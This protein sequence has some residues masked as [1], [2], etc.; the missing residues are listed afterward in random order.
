MFR[1]LLL[2]LLFSAMTSPVLAKIVAEQHVEKEIM[3][4]GDNGETRTER[5]KAEKVVPGE[6]VIY[7]L[8]FSNDADETADAVVLVMPVPPEVSYV[9]GT[10]AGQDANVTFSADGGQTYVARGRLTVAED[11]V[12]RPA[13]SNEITHIKWTLAETLPAKAKSEVS[14]RAILK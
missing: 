10:V 5:V 12:Q 11:G 1:S 9:E 8:R 7:S 2:S 4:R 3:V 6:E 13:K 14:F